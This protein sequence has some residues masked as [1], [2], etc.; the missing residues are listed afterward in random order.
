M[1]THSEP[2]LFVFAL[3]QTSQERTSVNACSKKDFQRPTRQSRTGKPRGKRLTAR[4]ITT[5]SLRLKELV[6]SRLYSLEGFD[7]SSGDNHPTLQNY[8]VRLAEEVLREFL[9][10]AKRLIIEPKG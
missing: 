9:A 2:D 3:H 8:F 1:I 6:T 7:V 4:C 10:S 5:S